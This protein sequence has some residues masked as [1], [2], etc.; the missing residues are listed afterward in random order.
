MTKN[1]FNARAAAL[2]TTLEESS[3]GWA[4]RSHIQLG[5]GLTLNDYLALESVMARAGL[6][7][8]TSEVVTITEDGRALARKIN[9]EL[10]KKTARSAG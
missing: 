9:E 3:S 6:I 4:P 5:L 10:A 7:T 8:N 2:L 1:E